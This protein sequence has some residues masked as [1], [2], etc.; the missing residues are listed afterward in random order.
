MTYELFDIIIDI[1]LFSIEQNVNTF[2]F[3]TSC[4]GQRRQKLK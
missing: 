4:V 1:K 2:K 3:Q